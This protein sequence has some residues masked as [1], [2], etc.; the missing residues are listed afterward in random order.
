MKS[1]K[2]WH[3]LFIA[4]FPALLYYAA[5]SSEALVNSIF[6][7][8]IYTFLGT[9]IVWGLLWII[10]KNVRLS[11]FYTSLILLWFFS[12]TH[13]QNVLKSSLKGFHIFVGYVVFFMLV[14]VVLSRKKL[15]K[16]FID[17]ASGF[18][19]IIGIYLVIS[20]FV[21]IIPSEIKRSQSEANIQVTKDIGIA[22][23]LERSLENKVTEKPDI[24]Y[25]VPDRYARADALEEFYGFD[26]S[27]FITELEK[28]GFY[29][30]DRSNANYPKTFLSLASSLNMRHLDALTHIVGAETRD[31][32]P[33]FEM[34]QN[35]MVAEYLKKQGYTF[36]YSGGWWEPTR[37]NRHADKNINLYADSDEFLRKYAQTTVLNPLF[38]H[39]FKKGDILGFSDNRVREN[40]LYKF[41]ELKKVA[42]EPGPK[43]VLVHMLFP[44]SPYVFDEKCQS[45]DTQ[46][47]N[48]DP[49]EYIAQ[50]QCANT[51]LLE[52]V[53]AIQSQSK[54]QP[55][56]ILQADEGPFNVDE[57]NKHGEGIDWEDASDDAFR[58]H[59]HIL[60]AY[61]VPAWQEDP[62]TIL[63]PSITP[64]NTFRLLLNEYFGTTFDALDDTSF[65]IPHLNY[66]YQYIEVTDV[67]L[68]I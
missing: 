39:V 50:L 22:M 66:P 58:Q 55:V 64:V 10:V 36:I 17:T 54:D 29:V 68:G 1:L 63:Y 23:E 21:R 14:A 13:V 49:Q 42:Q 56:M 35:N 28:R 24:Y 3:P 18:L 5:N 57:M 51:Q 12:Y 20:S 32:T 25:I 53:D 61:H 15:S 44:H 16:K 65:I 46:S 47:D 4:L 9:G 62:E 45:Y 60:N 43:F 41:A 67:V 11:A 48:R 59:M 26:N 6:S 52:I 30:A 33:V 19:T 27:D 37:V 2:F 31:N 8:I 38:H 40:H 7:P 34:V